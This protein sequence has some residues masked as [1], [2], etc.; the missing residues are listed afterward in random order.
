MLHQLS[1]G[2][3]AHLRCACRQQDWLDIHLHITRKPVFSLNM[4]SFSSS[5]QSTLDKMAAANPKLLAALPADRNTNRAAEEVGPLDMQPLAESAWGW[6][7][8]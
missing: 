5:A 8:K 7:P 6:R 4:P 1:I 2:C 3:V